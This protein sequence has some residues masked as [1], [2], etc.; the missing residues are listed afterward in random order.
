MRH[1]D[2]QIPYSKAPDGV[3]G[4][5]IRQRAGIYA[6]ESQHLIDILIS[7]TIRMWSFRMEVNNR[8][9]AWV[10]S[11]YLLGIIQLNSRMCAIFPRCRPN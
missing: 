4:Y 10:L 8:H 9:M 1:V 6:A 7:T 11:T 3:R 5:S 2:P